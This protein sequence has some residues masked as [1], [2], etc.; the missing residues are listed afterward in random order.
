MHTVL[1]AMA[2]YLIAK[3]TSQAGSNRYQANIECWLTKPENYV[4][5]LA[6]LGWQEINFEAKGK[7]NIHPM[8][9]TIIC[10]VERLVTASN[11]WYV[12]ICWLFTCISSSKIYKKY[13]KKLLYSYMRTVLQAMA[14]Y[15]VA[16]SDLVHKQDQT[17]IKPILTDEARELCHAACCSWLARDW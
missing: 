4:M 2:A 13:R 7:R 6:V 5:L 10:T 14:A 15:L 3:S 17:D 12:E 9:N 1:Q 8:H 16:K 11:A